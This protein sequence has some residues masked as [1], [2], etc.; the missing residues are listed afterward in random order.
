M[1][2]PFVPSSP[3]AR[4]VL[5][6]PRLRLHPWPVHLG[7][8]LA[9]SQSTAPAPQPIR[10]AG[11]AILTGLGTLVILTILATAAM[12]LTPPA[13]ADAV[14]PVRGGRL[15]FALSGSPDTLDPQKSSGTLTFQVVKSFYDTLVEVDEHGHLQPRLAVGW[16]LSADGTTWT[17]SLRPNV[18]F[19]NGQPFTA[20]DVK[21]TFERI[22][23]PATGSPKAG[24]FAAIERIEVLDPY[25]VRFILKEPSAPF[26]ATLAQGWAAILPHELI[27]KGYDFGAHPVGTGPFV[28]DRWVR[29][30]F[31][32]MNRN[33]RFWQPG[34]PYLDSVEIRF[35]SES[36][37]KVSGLLSGAFD[38][39]DMV[40]PLQLPLLQ[41]SPLVQVDRQ[42]GSMVL[43]MALNHRSPGLNDVRVRQAL[44]YALDREAILKSAYGP[45]TTITNTFMDPDSRY[46]PDSLGN[47]YPYNPARARELLAAA[48]YGNGTAKVGDRTVQLKPLVLDMVL[49]SNYP[50]HVKAGQ[51]IQA[52]LAE[53]GVQV[54]IQLV[55]WSTW[56]SQVYVGRHYDLTVIGHTGKL[57]PDG[58]LAGFGDPAKNYL[59]YSNPQVVEWIDQARTARNLEDR[60]ALYQKVLTQMS[61]DEAMV[62]L[63]VTDNLLIHRKTLHGWKQMYAIDT[64]DFSQAWKEQ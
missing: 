61:R 19:H 12:P 53:V 63:G 20:E 42:P 32:Q 51:L 50:P 4:S 37:V 35:V 23:N 48:G 7:R 49:P 3:S 9:S 57:D 27:A 16:N 38:A 8:T 56:L 17:F 18:F 25:T 28:F 26:I 21:A 15:T 1:S 31:I 6:F 5:S 13:A 59:N 45:F 52:Q 41:R 47:P 29:D 60:V 30:S 10:A 33:P 40:D 39:V 62:F 46:Y 2:A 11:K 55:D 64:Y 24:D 54:R 58:R 44:A 43:V 36:A 14:Q 22:K 34:L